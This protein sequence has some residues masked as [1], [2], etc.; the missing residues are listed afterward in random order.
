MS[1]CLQ[2]WVSKEAEFRVYADFGAEDYLVSLLRRQISQRTAAGLIANM[3]WQGCIACHHDT[4]NAREAR[5]ASRDATERHLRSYR[6]IGGDLAGRSRHRTDL[7]AMTDNLGISAPSAKACILLM[8]EHS[9]S[10]TTQMQTS[11]GVRHK[12]S[13]SW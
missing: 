8:A 5:W 9:Y 10:R 12:M 11:N 4:C 3:S 7:V 2:E 6:R 1:G 13:N